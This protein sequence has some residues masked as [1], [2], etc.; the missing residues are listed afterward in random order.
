MELYKKKLEYNKRRKFAFK[1]MN[2]RS[3]AR[4]ARLNINYADCRD[5]RFLKSDAD[6]VEPYHLFWSPH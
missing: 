1:E 2:K 3:S 6:S 5:F 4:G